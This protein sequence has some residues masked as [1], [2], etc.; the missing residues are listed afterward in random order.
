MEPTIKVNNLSVAY[1]LGK[2]AEFWALKDASLEVYQGEYII[3][4]GP[5]GCGKSTLLYC[6]AGLETP[7]KGEVLVDGDNLSK[8]SGKQMEYHRR[9][10]IGIVFQS[11]NLIS[12]LSVSDNITLPQV[13]G[14]IDREKRIK[15]AKILSEK[16]GIADF[17]HRFPKELSGGQ[18]QRVAITRSLIYSP[19][20]LLADE[21]VGNLD[22]NSAEITMK[23]LS[24]LNEKE[25]KTII[26]VTHDPHYLHYANRVFYMKDSK[27]TK[28]VVNPKKVNKSY[29]IKG[30]ITDLEKLSI[31]YP[32][33]TETKLKAKM[34]LNHL[35][36]PHGIEVYD[37]IE[38]VLDRYLLRKITEKD[39]LESLN[40]PP[41]NLYVQ[42]ARKLTEKAVKLFEEIEELEQ[43][44]LSEITPD[45]EKAVILR[46][47]LLDRYQGDLSLHQTERLKGVILKRIKKEIMRKDLQRILDA[48][49]KSGG[50]GLN[51]RTAKKFTSE[52]ELILMNK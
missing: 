35:L 14:N 41:I 11:F 33:L 27:I 5:S 42:T 9:L 50:V 6:L 40:K 30:E 28:V 29:G 13:F 21:P 7:T 36:L 45:E 37:K 16:F 46:R 51:S 48:P 8:L 2:S 25:G 43:E 24:E 1:N 4:Y 17:L 19:P 39:L 32:Y 47:L 18:Q 20:I 26:L 3:I 10:R 44:E 34:I 49:I 52:I 38:E 23:F 31:M 22:S 12:T 15:K